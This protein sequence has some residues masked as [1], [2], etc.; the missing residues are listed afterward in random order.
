[1]IQKLFLVCLGFAM[2]VG[3]FH[4]SIT[5]AQNPTIFHLCIVPTQLNSN[6]K[7]I[8][9][10]YLITLRNTSEVGFV[11]TEQAEVTIYSP[12]PL[13][14][15]TYHILPD[16]QTGGYRRNGKLATTYSSF[17]LPTS[18]TCAETYQ[19]ETSSSYYSTI[20]L[21]I[22]S[23]QALL[24]QT[25][26]NDDTNDDELFDLDVAEFLGVAALRF[27]SD[28]AQNSKSLQVIQI[29]EGTIE[30]TFPFMTSDTE[31]VLVANK[32]IG[33]EK[34][35]S[36]DDGFF[37]AGTAI[38]PANFSNRLARENG[39]SLFEILQNS[40]FNI[41][42][43]QG[44]TETYLT[45]GYLRLG[46][47]DTAASRDKP[48]E[49]DNNV[50]LLPIEGIIARYYPVESIFTFPDTSASLAGIQD[51]NTTLKVVEINNQGQLVIQ[52]GDDVSRIFII[53]AWLVE[54]K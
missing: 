14:A 4:T 48:F 26:I 7:P 47:S 50:G 23:N 46:M 40:R 30:L 20:P 53:E 13:I 15:A 37:A 51:I 44:L 43:A 54:V 31:F 18:R 21:P 1:M 9:E 52:E 16:A 34:S 2:V 36:P 28:N 10:P 8:A 5:Y 33:L 11:F 24:V 19:E 39:L 49:K 38:D 35:L 32:T 17:N 22:S 6:G 27:V 29:A 42:P 12:E 45:N 3:S 25:G 41:Y